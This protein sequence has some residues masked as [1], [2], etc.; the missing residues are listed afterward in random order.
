MDNVLTLRTALTEPRSTAGAARMSEAVLERLRSLPGVEVAASAVGLPLQSRAGGPF[1]IV[2]RENAGAAT[3]AGVVVPSSPGYFEAL[4]IP[5]LVGRALDARDDEA[6]VPVVVINQAMADRYWSDGGN[7]LNDRIRIGAGLPEAS[8]EPARQIVGIVGSVRQDGIVNDA[9]PAMYFPHA[10]LSDRLNDAFFPQ[11]DWIVRTSIDPAA[12]SALVHKT[13]RE[14]TR[15]Q[16][17]D[18]RSIEDTWLLSISRQRLNLWL[19]TLFGGAALLLGAVGVYGLV[20]YSVQQRRHEIGIRL[21]MGAR[22]G[23]ITS[24]VVGQGMQRV[25]VGV[26]AG[27]VAAYFLANV[28]ASTLFGVEPHDLAVFVTVP[29]VLLAVG[30]TAVCVPAFRAARVDPTLGLRCS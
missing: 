23:A 17:T 12:V 7:P 5:V 25:A 13:V 19:M 29:L 24:M 8:D 27:I 28:L 22:A 15:Q 3:G 14:E 11:L 26:A 21:A 16:V 9:E 20:E 4:R 10:Q 6:A 1:D 2:G 30:C 18:I